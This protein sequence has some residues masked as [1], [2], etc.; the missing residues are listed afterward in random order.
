MES[1]N[2]RRRSPRY[3]ALKGSRLAF[4]SASL[5]EKEGHGILLDLSKGGCRMG[6]ELPLI[7]NHYYRLVLQ[8]FIGNPV[9][10]ETALVCWHSKSEYGL[11][12]ITVGQD[13][14]ELLEQNLLQ[15]RS[16]S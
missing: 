3:Q 7:V 13:Q 11:K 12:F 10:I 2:E 8:A 1:S 6:T 14:D 15:L 9:T 16:V 4:L 5:Q